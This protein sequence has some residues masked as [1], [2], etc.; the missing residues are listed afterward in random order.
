ML[1]ARGDRAEIP[2]RAPGSRIPGGTYLPTGPRRQSDVDI[3]VRAEEREGRRAE[4]G[5]GDSSA[6]A[7]HP[8]GGY[9]AAEGVWHNY[10]ATSHCAC[11]FHS[12]RTSRKAHSSR[13]EEE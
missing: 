9:S 10:W 6:V 12:G 5:P 2:V 3:L 8:Q 7:P 13:R 1:W 11:P 4:P